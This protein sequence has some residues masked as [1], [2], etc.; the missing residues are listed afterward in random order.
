L[1]GGV[2]LGFPFSVLLGLFPKRKTKTGWS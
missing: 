2:M 1:L